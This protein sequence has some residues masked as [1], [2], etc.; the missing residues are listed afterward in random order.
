M[1]WGGRARK[2][3]MLGSNITTT[4]TPKFLLYIKQQGTFQKR[5]SQN[6][7]RSLLRARNSQPPRKTTKSLFR[8][9]LISLAQELVMD[10]EAWRAAIHGVA[11]SRTRLSDWTELNQP[12]WRPFTAQNTVVAR[13]SDGRGLEGTLRRCLCFHFVP[14]EK[15]DRGSLHPAKTPG[16][17]KPPPQPPMLPLQLEPGSHPGPWAST[18][19]FVYGSDVGG[20]ASVPWAGAPPLPVPPVR[21]PSTALASHCFPYPVFNC[22]FDKHGKEDT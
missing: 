9:H 6:T 20:R 1:F 21:L 19:L 12:S 18:V 14:E 2:L 3:P 17:L 4:G 16:P 13:E 22:K 5:P 10:R 7:A 11:K 15:G 8:L